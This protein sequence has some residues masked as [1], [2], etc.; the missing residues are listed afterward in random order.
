MASRSLSGFNRDFGN[1]A[2]AADLPNVAGSPTQIPSLQTGDRA[3]VLGT[4]GYTCLDATLGAA[5]WQLTS[6]LGGATSGA[7]VP[8]YT[9]LVNVASVVHVG[10]LYI[11][12]GEVVTVQVEATVTPAAGGACTF[13]VSL[14]I[15]SDITADADLSG[16][17]GTVLGDVIVVEADLVNDR[18]TV[19]TSAGGAAARDAHFAFTYRVQ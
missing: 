6:P 12:V 9:P 11:Q 17:G 8:V 18:A 1:I 4:G 10:A 7:Y 3:Y 19:R 13:G 5:V 14:P 2:A 15:P 16:A